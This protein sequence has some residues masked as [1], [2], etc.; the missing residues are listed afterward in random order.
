MVI[1]LR[2][3]AISSPLRLALDDL[4]QQMGSYVLS[5]RVGVIASAL[6]HSTRQPEDH[7]GICLQD[8]VK[9]GVSLTDAGVHHLNKQRP[10]MDQITRLR[11]R[12]LGG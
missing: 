6:G 7:F 1:A 8:R 11:S 9:H 2:Q 5:G 4:L 3:I 10:T 12:R